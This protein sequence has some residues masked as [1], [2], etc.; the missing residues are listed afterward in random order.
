MFGWLAHAFASV[1]TPTPSMPLA[2]SRCMVSVSGAE[3]ATRL[4]LLGSVLCLSAP[5]VDDTW[6]LPRGWLAAR[7]E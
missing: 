7:R 6:P 4:P 3:L 1:R 2:I 5:V